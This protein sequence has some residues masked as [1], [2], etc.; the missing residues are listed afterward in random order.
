MARVRFEFMAGVFSASFD[1]FW[2]LCQYLRKF[3]LPVVSMG[4]KAAVILGHDSRDDLPSTVILH[5][6]LRCSLAFGNVDRPFYFAV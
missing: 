4:P 6:W 1:S 5:T 2:G 3:L